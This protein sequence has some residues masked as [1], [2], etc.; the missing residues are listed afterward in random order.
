MYGAP[1][2]YFFNFTKKTNSG[3]TKRTNVLQFF[4]KKKEEKRTKLTCLSQTFNLITCA[5]S[6]TFRIWISPKPKR[7]YTVSVG[8]DKLKCI[9]V[10]DPGIITARKRS[11]GQG[12]I[13]APVCHSVH[14]GGLPQCK[15][16][17][18][19][20]QG[21]PP[22]KETLPAKETSCQGDPLPRRPPCQGD[23]PA[24][25][26]P[27]QAHTQGGNWGGSG[28]GPH[29]RGKFG[30]SDPGPHLRGNSG[31]SDPGP[32]RRGKFRGIRTT[33][34]PD[35]YCCGRYASYW[36]AFLLLDAPGP[37]YKK[38]GY[39]EHSA[40]KSGFLCIKIIDSNFQKFGYNEHMFRRNSYF[41]FSLLV[42]SGTQ[43]SWYILPEKLNTGLSIVPIS[44]RFASNSFTSSFPWF[45]LLFQR[46]DEQLNSWSVNG[47]S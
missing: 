17:Y 9:Q 6:S 10:A 5:F 37:D 31:G 11:L 3:P 40:I 29:T 33:P 14:R 21:D 45:V 32:H 1:N 20:C 13:F 43:C 15:L 26:T 27:L 38:L 35:D 25:K 24:K 23:P 8:K 46:Y 44:E 22:A 41:F 34:P 36:N 16:G 28:P 39:N 12:N 47:D 30:G 18:P 4:F 19:L 42:V 2:L 7:T